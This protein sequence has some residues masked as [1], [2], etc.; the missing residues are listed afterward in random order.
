MRA[1]PTRA[2]PQTRYKQVY[3]I[4]I[5]WDSDDL[6]VSAELEDLETCFKRY[7]RF[8][9]ERFDIPTENSHLDL[10]LRIG[11]FIKQH[12]GPDSLLIVYY[13]GHGQIDDARQ[14][15][16]KATRRPGSPW[17]Q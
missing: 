16:W 5:R 10:M 7:Y 15:T 3:S 17:L 11:Q 14:S 4:L 13:G 12:E 9:T 8:E 2:H 6:D 1:L